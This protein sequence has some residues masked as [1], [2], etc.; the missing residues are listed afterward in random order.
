MSLTLFPDATIYPDGFQYVPEFISG[1]EELYLL[2]QIEKTSFHN[3][4]FQGFEARRRVASFG[5]D[6]SF[7]RRE[8]VQGADIPGCFR[9]IIQ[10]VADYL[11]F[12]EDALA[13]L[14]LTEYPAGAVINWHRDAPPFELIACISLRSDCTFRLKP[15]DKAGQRKDAIISLP[16]LRRSLYMMQGEVRTCWLHSIPALSSTRY[17][18]TFRTLRDAYKKG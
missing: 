7:E 11:S 3:F 8:L 13:E 14:L 17:S 1:Q 16:L 18:I 10:K 12:P 5:W 15:Y 2:S 6:W 9:P 4:Q